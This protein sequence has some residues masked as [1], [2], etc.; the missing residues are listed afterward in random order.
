[1][2]TERYLSRMRKPRQTPEQEKARR[3]Y[4]ARGQ[5]I[6]SGQLQGLL[7]NGSKAVRP[8]IRELIDAAIS[9]KRL[10]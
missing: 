5:R 7:E 9:K 1:M 6:R 10:N 4:Q 2:I 8:E 3:D